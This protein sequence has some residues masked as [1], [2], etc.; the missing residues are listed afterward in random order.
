MA[1]A[2]ELRTRWTRESIRLG[3]EAELERV[4]QE[5][6]SL[7]R[8]LR[9]MERREPPEP[10]LPATNQLHTELI[11]SGGGAANHD[12]AWKDGDVGEASPLVQ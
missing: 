4:K 8:K 7:E 5:R 1:Y 11:V 3:I 9:A 6:D 2:V 10:A 12:A